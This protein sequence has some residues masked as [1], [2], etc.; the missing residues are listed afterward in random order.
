MNALRSE[1]GAALTIAVI[2]G[3]LIALIA[4]FVLNLSYNQT[5]QIEAVG[6]TRTANFYKAQA[7]LV[8][9]NW[10][11]RNDVMPPGTTGSF[12]T[13]TTPADPAPY[14]IDIETHTVTAASG[15]NCAGANDDVKV[16][17]GPRDAATGLRPIDAMGLDK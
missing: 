11:I 15:G 17:I 4:G 3:T 8:D 2:F 1:N 10:R 6:P 7:G 9:A 5:R 16:D 14:C 12:K 13:T